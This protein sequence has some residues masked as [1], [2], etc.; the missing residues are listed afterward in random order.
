MPTQQP[1]SR[2]ISGIG[3]FLWTRLSL[4]AIRRQAPHPRLPG[5]MHRLTHL[6]DSSQAAGRAVEYEQQS[7]DRE[8]SGPGM[9]LVAPPRCCLDTRKPSRNPSQRIMPQACRLLP[10]LGS[11]PLEAPLPALVTPGRCCLDSRKPSRSPSQSIGLRVASTP[12]T[13]LYPETPL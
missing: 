6:L 7:S 4:V 3:M 13:P 2:L 8:G 12:E 1:L 5:L 9:P 11:A 10:L